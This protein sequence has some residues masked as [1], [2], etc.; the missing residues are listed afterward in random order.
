ML[1]KVLESDFINFYERYKPRNLAK[2][3]NYDILSLLVYSYYYIFYYCV[4][5]VHVYLYLK[6]CKQF[7][8][9]NMSYSC[10]K[11]LSILSKNVYIN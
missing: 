6:F 11:L 3:K 4:V 5:L 10:L 2:T 9:Q 7:L 8:I 1:N